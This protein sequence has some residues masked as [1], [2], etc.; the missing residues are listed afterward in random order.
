[1]SN[2]NLET[3][4]YCGWDP[5]TQGCKGTNFSIYICILQLFQ[6][7]KTKK[8]IGKIALGHDDCSR[9]KLNPRDRRQRHD[10][11]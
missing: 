8:T 5:M 1:M 6:K 3:S 7:R 10:P 2:L 4:T 11:E 9:P